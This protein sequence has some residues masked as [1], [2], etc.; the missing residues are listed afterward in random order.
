M[1]D[2]APPTGPP[3]PRAPE[4]PSGWTAR[5]NDQY[6]EWYVLAILLIPFCAASCHKPLY[7]SI[8]SAS[9]LANALIPGSTSISTPRSPN[10]TSLRTPSIPTVKLRLQIPLQATMATPATPPT[11]PTPRRT[12]TATQATWAALHPEA[13]RKMRMLAWRPGY[14]PKRT[15]EAAVAATAAVLPTHT[16]RE[17]APAHTLRLDTAPTLLPSS[18]SRARAAR[19][20]C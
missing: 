12:P 16:A 17:E 2:F 9:T 11:L 7:R 13:S 20:V 8:L 15:R 10:G 1:S 5:W 19:E 6:K 3:P 18:S 14:R 4:V